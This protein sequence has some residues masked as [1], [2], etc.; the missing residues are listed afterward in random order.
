MLF[1]LALT[2]ERVYK[3]CKLCGKT[4]KISDQAPTKENK[5]TK[6]NPQSLAP[7][8]DLVKKNY[9]ISLALGTLF[10]LVQMFPS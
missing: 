7:P 6:E 4:R 10:F 8:K 2:L 9:L 3:F 1:I 5:I